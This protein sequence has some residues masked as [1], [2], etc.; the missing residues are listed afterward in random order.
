MKILLTNDDG[1]FAQGIR[2][3]A[4]A[5]IDIG[6]VFVVAPNRQR[7]ATGHAI[8][9]HEPLRA[10]KIDY[11]D[12]KL[13]AW[14]VSGTPSDCVKLGIEALMKDLPDIV[15]SG[16]NRGPNLGTDVL[17]SGTVS[18]AIE[19]AMLGFPSVAVS[20]ASFKD[21]DYSFAAKFSK[22]IAKLVIEKQLPKDTL[23]NVN[24]PNQ[25]E[26][27]IQGVKITTL[28]VRKYKNS[29]IE[30]IDPHGEP[31]YWLGGEAVDEINGEET[32]IHSINQGYISITPIHF[33]LTKFELLE[34]LEQWNIQK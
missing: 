13:Q 29:F 24:I 8:T 18:A 22:K 17:Y 25:N 11:F 9:M 26:E 2:D 15:F 31:Y 32:D 6:D 19:G 12:M 30:R 27:V 23:L 16:I 10:E 7:S 20:L 28:G 33:D 34:R 21:L 5:L 3:L 1:I 4:K 14:A